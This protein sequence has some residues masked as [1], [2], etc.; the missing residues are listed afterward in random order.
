MCL[1]Q[2]TYIYHSDITTVDLQR[3][4]ADGIKGIIL[5]LDSTIMA[6][7]SGLIEERVS[8]WLN[9]AEQNFKL[10]VLT[11]NKNE[12]YLQRAAKSLPILLVGRAAKPSRKALFNLLDKLDLIPEEA[13][14]IGDRP[15]TDILA[16]KRAGMKT[17]LVSP[18][19]TMNEHALVKYVRKL[20]RLVIKF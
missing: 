9:Q 16:G 19:S 7:R 18:L 15:L 10:A 14:L 8:Q 13:V 6:P 20:E 5:D 3:L 12:K 2:P 4:A 11:N 17:C 1:L